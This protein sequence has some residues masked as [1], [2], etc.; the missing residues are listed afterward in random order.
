MIITLLSWCFIFGCSIVFG[1]VFT[2]KIMPETFQN[3]TKIDVYFVSGLMILNV[4]AQIC[5]IFIKVGEMAFL[6]MTVIV[7]AML[8]WCLVEYKIRGS[9]LNLVNIKKVETWKICITIMIGGATLLFT[10]KSPEFVDTYLYHI[11]AIRWIEW[12]RDL[13][14]CTIASPIIVLFCHFKHCFRFR[15]L[16]S[17]YIL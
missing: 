5:S 2:K 9:Q 11:Q 7:L 6:I 4:Y 17:L 10:I 14:I 13:E 12:F 1:N 8:V 16:Q 15:G 3:T